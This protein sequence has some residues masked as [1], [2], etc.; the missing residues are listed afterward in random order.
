MKAD[1]RK[2]EAVNSKATKSSSK[3]YQL[4][5]TVAVPRE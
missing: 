1:S 2:D 4:A 5:L 3:K